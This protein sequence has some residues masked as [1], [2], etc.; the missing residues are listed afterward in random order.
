MLKRLREASISQESSTSSARQITVTS[1]RESKNPTPL[2]QQHPQTTKPVLGQTGRGPSLL[3]L[4]A[5]KR[6]TRNLRNKYHRS[7]S[8]YG[9][10][11]HSTSIQVQREPTYRMEPKNK[12]NPEEAGNVIKSIIDQRM[13]GFKY[14]P[15]FCSNMCKLLSDEIKDGIKKLKYDRYKIVAVVHIGERKDQSTVVASRCAWDKK[16]DNF[17][18]YTFETPSLF[19]TA[20]VFGIYNE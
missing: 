17:A 2:P 1:P 4:L 11:R 14:H 7:G 8:L 9:S 12:F 10:S 3:G 19:C 20:S 16:L 5:A 15:K 13:K 18:T 6:F